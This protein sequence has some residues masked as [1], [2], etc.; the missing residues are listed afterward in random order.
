MPKVWIMSSNAILPSAKAD[1]CD[2]EGSGLLS[3]PGQHLEQGEV[4][5]REM[6]RDDE[7]L[8]RMGY[9][10]ELNR[11]LGL[12]ENWA[13][14][15]A[16]MNFVSGMPVLF[17]WVMMTGGPQAAVTSWSL[18]STV[19]CALALALAEI[20]AALPTAG[21][22]Y[23]WTYSLGGPEWGPF[24]SWMTAWWNW[25]AWVLA[26][27]GTQQGATN[28]LISALQINYPRAA[29]LGD[30]WFSLLVILAGLIIA[31]I[32]NVTSQRWLRLYFRFA[33]AIFF[34]LLLLFWIWFPVAASGKFQSADFV[35]KKFHNGINRGPAKQA[36]DTYCWIISLLFGAWEFGGYDASAH[37]AEE[38]KDA[39]KTVARGMWLSTLSTTILSIPT[40]IMI[41]FC[42]QN[43]EALTTAEY[44]NNWAEFLVQVVGSRGATAILVMNWIDCTCATAAVI[45]SAQRVTFAISRDN[46]LPGSSLFKKVSGA[47]S[48]PINSALLVVF[49]AAAVSC[50]VLGSSVAFGAI[51]AT[52]VICQSMSYL[53]VLI[54]RHTL[55]TKRFQPAAWNLGRLSQPMGYFCILWLSFLSVILLLPQVFPVTLEALNY[56]PICLLIVTLVSVIGWIFPKRGGRYWFKGPSKTLPDGAT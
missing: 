42:V 26:V 40:L 14:T 13:A 30:G 8:A 55:G 56:S 25:S 47:N 5:A 35:F 38:T 43:F 50:T 16:C 10:Q 29:Y 15:F 41:L 19:S 6:S 21:G 4:D 53:F 32:P 12:F 24:L 36:S 20:G 1:A 7:M 17:G 22:I 11:G 31:L 45:L 27:P 44:A 2:R 51:T 23:F 33:M 28:F 34:V 54:T 18:V 48:A 39:S 52:T 9:K 3:P 37:L 49:I 46:I